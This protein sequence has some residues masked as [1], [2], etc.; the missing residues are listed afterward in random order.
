MERRHLVNEAALPAVRR[1]KDLVTM[2]E[3]E[4]AGERLIA[5][6]E[7]KTRLI[8]PDEREIVAC[9][10]MG[11][12]LTALS[13]PGTDPVQKITIMP[14]GRHSGTG[15]HHACAHR[16]PVPDEKRRICSIASASFRVAAQWFHA[17]L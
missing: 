2:L 10:E 1:N 11:H 9:H 15:I 3:F 14:R 12:A 7:K 8:N 4:V 6:L 13:L 17:N 16:R 5:G